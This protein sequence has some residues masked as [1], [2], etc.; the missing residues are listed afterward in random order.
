MRV[1]IAALGL[2]LLAGCSLPALPGPSVPPAPPAAV[3]GP[4]APT[5]VAVERLG[6]RSTL[7]PTGQNPDGTAEVPPVDQ[8]QQASFLDWAEDQVAARPLVI[9]GHINGR[10]DGKS[11]PGVFAKLDQ[12][13]PGDTVVVSYADGSAVTYLIKRVRQVPKTGFPTQEVY[14]SAPGQIRLVT[15]DG[16]FDRA[17]RSYRDNFIVFGERQA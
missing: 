5:S 3:T 10:V 11:V 12:I 17:A 2:V 16:T 4:P 15:C 7:I 9:Y 8:P 6:V 14:D 13:K 1:L